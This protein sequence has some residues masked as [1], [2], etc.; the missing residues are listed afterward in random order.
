MGNENQ[1]HMP[2]IEKDNMKKLQESWKE[3]EIVII[4]EGVAEKDVLT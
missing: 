3:N 1:Q 2:V 4:L